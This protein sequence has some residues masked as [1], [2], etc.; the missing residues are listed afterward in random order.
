LF[1]NDWNDTLKHPVFTNV[2]KQAGVLIEGYGLGVNIVDIN[3]DG[4]KDI[5]VSNDYISN[6]ILYINNHNGTFTD[7]CAEYFKHTSKNGMGNDIADINNDGLPDLIELDMAPADNYRLKMMYN[8][9][10][11]ETLLNYPRFG[12]IT[13]YARNTLQL[14]QGNRVLSTDSI[15]DP[16]FSEVAYFAGIAHTDWS[17]APLAVDIDNDGYRDLMISNGLPHDMSDL[18]FMAYRNYEIYKAS[19]EDLIKKIPPAEVP[20]Y[21]FHNNGDVTFSNKTKDWDGISRRSQPGWLMLT[22]TATAMWMLSSTI[23]ICPQ[24]CYRI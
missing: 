13:Q 17:W 5:Y 15:G 12:Y 11:Y 22:L 23:Q 6:D 8:D 21:I 2:S 20:N 19:T 7:K 16:V 9:I 10:K 18:D 1:R 3:N 14:N 24:Q 4:W